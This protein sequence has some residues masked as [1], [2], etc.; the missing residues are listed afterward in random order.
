MRMQ[1]QCLASLSGLRIQHCLT[2]VQ[3]SS[4]SSDLTPSLG[5]SICHRCGPRKT[6]QTNK[7]KPKH[8]KYPLPQQLHSQG[9]FVENNSTSVKMFTVSYF[10]A[11][12]LAY[13]N[14]QARDQKS[15]PCHSSNLS[16]CSDN[17]IFLTHCITR[18]LHIL[19]FWKDFMEILPNILMCLLKKKN[20]N[21]IAIRIVFKKQHIKNGIYRAI[22][23]NNG[24]FPGG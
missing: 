15:N 2:V 9:F 1:V 12:P 5:T 14:F 24:E 10:W 19:L 18:E 13:E 16:H 11:M 21:L 7:Q 6:K 3:A 17:T 8:L 22:K 23:S 20:T 4:Y